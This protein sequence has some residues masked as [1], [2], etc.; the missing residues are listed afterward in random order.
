[1]LRYVAHNPRT[2]PFGASTLAAVKAETGS[3]SR[4]LS[5]L[6]ELELL[7]AED[8]DGRKRVWVHDARLE[9]YLRGA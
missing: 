6:L 8:N 4:V 2:Q 9:F 3:I 5:R 7:R 1:M